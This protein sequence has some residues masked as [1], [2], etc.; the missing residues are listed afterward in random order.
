MPELFLITIT[1]YLLIWCVFITTT[2]NNKFINKHLIILILETLIIMLFLLIWNNKTTTILFYNS[3]IIDIFTTK[4]K[5]LILIFTIIYFLFTYNYVTKKKLLDYEFPLLIL[6]SIFATLVLISSYDL[7]TLYLSIELQSLCFY[8]LAA[9]QRTSR[10][11][12]EAGLKYFI[13]G[14]CS[15]SF[16]LFGMS[17]I[18]G[19]TGSTNF[20][21]IAKILAEYKLTSQVIPHSIELGLIFFIIGFLFKLTA[22]PFHIW[23]P[24]VYEGS[25]LIVT[26]FFATIPKF[27]IFILFTKLLYITFFDLILI[28]QPLLTITAA[29]TILFA[30]FATLAQ[31]KIK[32]FLAYSSISHVGYMLIGLTTGTITGIHAFLLYLIT[33]IITLFAFFGM[34]LNLK[35]NNK[36]LIYLT[37][38]L[39]IKP[40]T[41]K[42]IFI[43]LLFSISGIPPLLGFFTKFYIFFSAIEASYYILPFIGIITSTIGAFY[44]IRIIKIIQFEKLYHSITITKENTLSINFIIYLLCIL[45]F[46]FFAPN[47]LFLEVYKLCLLL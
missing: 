7:I 5:I 20:E 41:F 46:F 29:I 31:R 8:I 38:L 13:L 36:N 35:K 14:A 15:S 32:R 17:F 28:W 2:L 18:Y 42:I 45:C 47:F 10:F 12:S 6:I 22:V 3:L 33:Y 16:L 30:T 25:P 27:A 40:I 26:T 44:Y 9:I 21:D 39:H 19:F 1:L 23:S 11:S 34:L 37:D 4:I 24:D 43:L